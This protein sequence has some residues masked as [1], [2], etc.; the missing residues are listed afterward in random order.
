M[1]CPHTCEAE[2]SLI[3][4]SADKGYV[5]TAT[6]VDAETGEPLPFVQVYVAEGHGALTNDEGQFSLD[7]GPSD[8]LVVT[9]MGYQRV[10][11][12]ASELPRV[13][14]LVPSVT[15]LREVTVYAPQ[16]ILWQVV[17]QMER[18]Y[19]A[20]KNASAYYYMRQTYRMA[21]ASQMAEAYFQA[22]CANNLRDV[23]FVAG[24]MFH[25]DGGGKRL[26][27]DLS[28]IHATLSL[29]PMIKGES[30]WREALIPLNQ[31]RFRRRYNYVQDYRTT[32]TTLDNADGR[33]IM[34][35]RFAPAREG[36]PR[37]AVMTGDLYVDADSLWPVGFQGRLE[38]IKLQTNLDGED[39][40]GLATIHV[41]ITYGHMRGYNHVLGISTRLVSDGID[42]RTVAYNVDRLDIPKDVEA[43]RSDNLL[44]AIWRTHK[45]AAWWRSNV[46]LPTQA[47]KRLMQESGVEL[48]DGD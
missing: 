19:V 4:H 32:I 6:I 24:R 26:S 33:H 3:E 28:N 34:C 44:V 45:D 15:A 47:E 46:I 10:R 29:A 48:E 35:I 7:V 37:H 21:G 42:C 31:K 27:L 41:S 20:H 1:A 38:G 14:R 13:L 9:C 23:E 30:F 40:K 18:D 2:S 16:D 12:K 22:D 43:S 17:S 25:A 39:S 8:V 5:A 11:L 36:K